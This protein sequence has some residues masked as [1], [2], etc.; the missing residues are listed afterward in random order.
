MYTFWRTEEIT[1]SYINGKRIWKQL[2][3]DLRKEK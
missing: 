1:R 2:T 3:V